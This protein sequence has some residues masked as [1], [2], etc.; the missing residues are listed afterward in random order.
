MSVRQVAFGAR[1][2]ERLRKSI[3]RHRLVMRRICSRFQEI[4]SGTVSVESR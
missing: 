2:G 3:L 1:R 4:V